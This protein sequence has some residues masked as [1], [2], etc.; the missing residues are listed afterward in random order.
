MLTRFAAWIL[1]ISSYI[2]LF[3]ILIINNIIV[4]YEKMIANEPYKNN[5]YISVGIVVVIS[6]SYLLLRVVLKAANT[7]NES[8]TINNISK[9]NDSI[10]G[11]LFSY[12]VPF[13]LINTSDIREIIT[14][15]LV[16]I[17][18]GIICVENELV[19]I[20][21]TLYLL[22]YNIYLLDQNVV[23][24][25]KKDRSNIIRRNRINC[26]QLSNKVYLD[27]NQ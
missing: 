11:Y 24:I 26:A 19:Y 25:S 10:L 6:L 14:F 4:V 12:L 5:L 22:R 20:N 1:Y 15:A 2:P 16:F 7:N 9:S 13:M 8:I 21:P 17:V 23:L 27:L 18:M 3:F